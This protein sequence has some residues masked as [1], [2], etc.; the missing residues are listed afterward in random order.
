LQ[1]YYEPTLADPQQIPSRT[2]TQAIPAGEYTFDWA[3]APRIGLT[4]DVTGDGRSKAYLNAARYFERVPNDLA[5]RSLS[6]EAGLGS[7]QWSDWSLANGGPITASQLSRGRVVGSQTS[8]ADGTK[9]PYVDEYVIGWQQELGRDVSYELRGIYREQGRAL[10][11][12]QFNTVEATE[13]YYA[14]YYMGVP[15]DPNGIDHIPFP[16]DTGLIC[17]LPTPTG[18]PLVLRSATTFLAIPV[19]TLRPDSRRPCGSTTPSS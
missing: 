4:W 6:N 15:G 18:T 11:D 12:V 10:E 14:Y 1:Y 13:N 16:Y 17:A 3:F 2:G 8:V 9:L 7:M 5:I 19:R